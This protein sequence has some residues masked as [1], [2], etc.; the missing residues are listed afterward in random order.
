LQ[1]P[2]VDSLEI[3]FSQF[4]IFSTH[5]NYGEFVERNFGSSHVYWRLDA[6][7]GK[8]EGIFF[9]FGESEF[10]RPGIVCF[11]YFHPWKKV[12]VAYDSEGGDIKAKTRKVLVVT[13]HKCSA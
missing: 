9:L 11:L 8:L 2:S 3:S 13:Y 5:C 1:A 4:D 10:K 7:L 12:T 6:M